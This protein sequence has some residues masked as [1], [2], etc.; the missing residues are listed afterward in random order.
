MA[1]PHYSSYSR[2]EMLPVTVAK[3]GDVIE[4]GLLIELCEREHV[5]VFLLAA[6]A[7]AEATAFVTGGCFSLFSGVCQIKRNRSEL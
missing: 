4:D 6:A 5:P 3:P 7:R 2:M 1:L